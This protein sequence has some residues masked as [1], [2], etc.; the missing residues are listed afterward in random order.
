MA[1]LQGTLRL[2]T[3]GRYWR[4]RLVC[5]LVITIMVG[6]LTYA[7]TYK[8][9]VVIST[10]GG[11]TSIAPGSSSTVTPSTATPLVSPTRH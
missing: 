1:T 6:T 8:A 11:T 5:A 3:E 2:Q 10:P 7:A 4:A 9:L